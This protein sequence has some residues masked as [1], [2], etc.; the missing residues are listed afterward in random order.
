MPKAFSFSKRD[1][2]ILLFS[3]SYYFLR[4]VVACLDFQQLI[5]CLPISYI[6]QSKAP[7]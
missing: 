2:M 5:S 3:A 4:T 1:K 6:S 7:G